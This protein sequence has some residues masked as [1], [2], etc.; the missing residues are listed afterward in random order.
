[1]IE[2]K[3]AGENTTEIT[4]ALKEASEFWDMFKLSFRMDDGQFVP[5]LVA[6]MLD[7]LLVKMNDITGMYAALPSK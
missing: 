6:L 5:G 1:M 4:R 3:A 2:L 7:K